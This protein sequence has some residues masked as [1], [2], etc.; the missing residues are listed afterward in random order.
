[1]DITLYFRAIAALAVV[2]GLIWLL[3]AIMKRYGLGHAIAKKN[4]I[5]RLGIE[6]VMSIDA[7]RRLLLIKRDDVEHLILLGATTEQV[8]ETG[9]DSSS[10]DIKEK[11]HHLQEVKHDAG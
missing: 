8:I 11:I 2:A 6:E 3:A 1:M 9:I 10:S 4:S 5:S 7:K